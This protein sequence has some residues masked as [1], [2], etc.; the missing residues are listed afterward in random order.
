[1]SLHQKPELL[2]RIKLFITISLWA[3]SFVATKIAVGEVSPVTVIWLRFLIGSLILGLIAGRRSELAFPPR[4][5]LAKLVITGFSGVALHH[6]LQSSALVTVEATTTAWIV[7]TIPVFM[8][9]LGWI[10][11][12]EKPGW[13]TIIGTL[14]AAAGVLLV[15]GK[16]NMGALISADF[17][18]PGDI[19]VLLSALNWAVFSII[20]R[21]LLKRYSAA[22]FTFYT[23]LF[24]WLII[25]VPF[26]AGARWNELSQLSPNGWISVLYLGALCSA[27]GYIFYN[28]GLQALSASQVGVF[29]Y[30]QPI[31]T[32]LV[33]AM[34]LSEK[35]L[36]TTIVGGA[37]ILLGVWQVN[38][39]SINA[40]A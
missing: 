7:S 12:K 31:I 6:M 27:L 19:L 38:R 2:A 35:V 37:L 36:P 17:G 8:V 15:V 24:G 32:T 25:S 39:S 29:L 22:R 28:D 3:G 1:M 30:M 9:L 26:A 13:V 34:L 23:L 21:P 20:S 5:D 33:A 40:R 4:V 14:L 18:K 10:F 11:L 16:G